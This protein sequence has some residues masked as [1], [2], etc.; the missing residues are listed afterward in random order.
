MYDCIVVGAGYAGLTAAR[1]LKQA[2]KNILL[3][4]ARE[5]VGGRVYT[6]FLEDGSYADLGAQWIGANQHRIYA[7]AKEF[8]ISTFPT[9]DKGKSSLYFNQKIKLYK[10]IIP[11][12]PLFALLN[13]DAAIKK[14]NRLSKQIDLESPWLS[15]D[16]AIWDGISLAQWMDKHLKNSKARKLFTVAAEAIFATD[17]ANI[18]MLHVLFYTR[19]GKDFDTLM[20]IKKGAQQ[21]RIAGGAQSICVAMAAEL[22]NCIRLNSGVTSVE[23]SAAEVIVNGDGFAFAAKKLLLAV[24]PA[25]ANK[26]HFAQPLPEQ[27][28]LF[29]QQNFMGSVMK[30]YA[31]YKT[32][33]WRQQKKNGLCA[34][35]G[36][37][38]SVCFDNSPEDGSKGIL[39]GFALAESAKAMLLLSE[40]D[41][42]KIVLGNFVRYF[43]NEAALPNYYI[44]HCFTEEPWSLGCYAGMMP[45]NGWTSSGAAARSITGHIHWAGTETATEWNGYMEGAVRSGERAALEILQQE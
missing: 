42:K 11:P 29:L 9:Y 45:V 6:K 30:C 7:L 20:N 22:E 21:D 14:I 26:I 19:S 27:K 3:L 39:M 18:A 2:G 25:V 33:F 12:L 32:P 8:G 10:G 16:A 44:D 1:N 43:G 36:E 15:K 31:V 37:P 40:P 13:L 23:Q 35:P 4:E 5:R 17:A 28:K 24:P 34:A 41:R 38:I